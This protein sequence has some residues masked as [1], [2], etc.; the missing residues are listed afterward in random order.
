M[1]HRAN[2]AEMEIWAGRIEEL[3]HS[4]EHNQRITERTS[5]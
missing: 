5:E 2:K 4:L 1:A 3:Q